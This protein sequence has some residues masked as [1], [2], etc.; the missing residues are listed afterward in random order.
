[1]HQRHRVHRRAPQRVAQH[2]RLDGATERHVLPDAFLA[3]GA[4]Q[5]GE[6]L[7]ERAI[8]EREGTL[9]HTVAHRHLH[10]A[11]RRRRADEHRTGGTEQARER[12]F[13]PRQQL[14]H[15]TRTV[16][17]HGALH[18]AQHLGVHVSGTGE[19]EAPEGGRGRGGGSRD[20]RRGRHAV[21]R[22]S[23]S[24]RPSSTT[25]LVFTRRTPSSPH[26]LSSCSDTSLSIPFTASVTTNS[27]VWGRRSS[28]PSI[29][30]LS[31]TSVATPY[32]TMSSGASTSS[33]VS[34]LPLL[35]TS[36]RCL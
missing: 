19:E 8:D 17:D 20:G 30:A 24:T 28:K 21:A 5:V 31:H 16:P 34:T 1:M 11:G 15:G 7:A 32:S 36:K 12:G 33:T 29:A 18:G 13:E 22:A 27:R 2:V 6:P 9:A 14:L 10:K 4:H 35:N 25:S 26:S 3:G 23:S